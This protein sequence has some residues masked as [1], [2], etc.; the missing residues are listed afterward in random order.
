VLDQR[1]VHRLDGLALEAADQ[2]EA[3]QLSPVAPLGSCS[4]VAPTSQDRTLSSVRGTEV[5]SDPTNVLALECVRRLPEQPASHVHL[6]TIHQVLRVHALP[7]NTGFSRHFRLF[8]LAGGR[9]RPR[10]GRLRGRRH[11]GS[12]ANLRSNLRR[13]RDPGMHVPRAP[14]DRLRNGTQSGS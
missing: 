3:L 5:V 14:R 10:R 9:S 12:R 2:F 8:A 1:T 4:V 7:P 13:R 6:C 11:H